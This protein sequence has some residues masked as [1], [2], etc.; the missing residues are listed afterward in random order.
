MVADKQWLRNLVSPLLA[1]ESL[2]GVSGTTL[3]LGGNGAVFGPRWV[4]QSRATGHQTGGV[5]Y[6]TGNIAYRKSVLVSVGLFDE[7]FDPKYRGDTDM[8]LRVLKA[9]FKIAYQET[10]VAYHPVQKLSV[11]GLLKRGT[12]MHKDVLLYKKYG[13]EVLRELG[14][15]ITKPVIKGASALGLASVGIVF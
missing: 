12:M 9:G 1:D 6:G 14:G 10:A 15:P 7:K 5:K 2:G 13:K 3:P 8:G 4:D 11:A